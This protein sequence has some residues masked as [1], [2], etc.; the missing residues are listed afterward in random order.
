MQKFLELANYYQQFIQDFV[1]IARLLHDL[2][3]KDQKWDLTERQ[4]K[5]F[6]E[7]KEKFT[8]ELLTIPDLNKK[9]ENRSQCIR[10]YNRRGLIYGM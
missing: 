6:K 5:A 4:E 3:K 2:V 7:L 8:K 10:L 9:N 1:S